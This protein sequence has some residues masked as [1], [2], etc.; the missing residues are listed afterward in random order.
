VA[1]QVGD[2]NGR[3]GQVRLV[4]AIDRGGFLLA[5]CLE[6]LRLGEQGIVRCSNSKLIAVLG[7]PA[8]LGR[9]PFALHCR[10][11]RGW[12]HQVCE[13]LSRAYL[14]IALHDRRSYS[15]GL[16]IAI[17]SHIYIYMHS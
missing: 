15:E 10:T 4:A 6:F 3:I 1:A 2:Q 13:A 17:A 11:P 16:K 9:P 12:A 8:S 5:L 14:I 7:W